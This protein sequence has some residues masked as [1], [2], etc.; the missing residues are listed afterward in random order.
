MARAQ[1]LA[2]GQGFLFLPP[3]PDQKWHQPGSYSVGAGNSFT[4]AKQLELRSGSS[5]QTSVKIEN[6]CAL[7]HAFMACWLNIGTTCIFLQ[8]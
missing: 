7:L 3:Y 1:F 6:M 2:Q 4:R 5:L 8:V